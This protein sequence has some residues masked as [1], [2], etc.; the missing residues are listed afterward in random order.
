MASRQAEKASPNPPPSL[1]SLPSAL[2]VP[3]SPIP[4]QLLTPLSSPPVATTTSRHS[5][6]RRRRR[7]VM[8]RAPDMQPYIRRP[9][10][11]PPPSSFNT[12][13]SLTL[14]FQCQ[15]IQ[16]HALGR[17][18]LLISPSPLLTTTTTTTTII[19]TTMSL[20]LR[21]PCIPSTASFSA[22]SPCPPYAPNS[23]VITT[24]LIQMR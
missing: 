3:C 18:D 21:A 15:N 8:F 22:S 19:T 14:A 11:T 13:T 12:I 7:R 9:P 16:K 4:S 17:S 24:Y 1:L 6:H 2:L 5:H 10:P 20:S 23:P